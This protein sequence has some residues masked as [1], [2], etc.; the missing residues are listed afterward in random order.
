MRGAWA[1]FSSLK[2]P[3]FARLYAAQT[4][5]LLGDAL[6]WVALALLAFELAGLQ[7]ALVLGVALTLRVTA[8][9]VFSPLAGALADRLS[10][11]VIMVTANLARVG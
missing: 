6:I 8:F 7:A 5:S 1:V 3:V 10:R 11:K 4:A 2:N 9:V